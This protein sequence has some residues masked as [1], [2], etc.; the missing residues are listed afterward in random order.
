MEDIIIRGTAANGQIRAFAA[1]TK[2]LCEEARRRHDMSPIGAVALGRLLTGGAMMGTMMKNDADIVTIQIKG[3]GPIGSMTV[4]ADPRGRVKGYVANPQVMLPLKDGKL[5]IAGALGIG[6][7]S[8]IKDIGL[9]EPYV[10]DTILITSEIGDDL[11]YYFAT[12]EQVPSSVALGVLMNKDNTVEQA[13]GFI[14]QLM[15][16]AD[17]E[18]VDRLEKSVREVKSVTELLEAGM[19]PEDILRQV[20]GDM[21]FQVLD[22]ITPQFYCNCSKDRVSKAIMSIGKK[23]IQDMI[24][25]GKPI[26]VN[27]H[28]C[29]TN[30]TFSVDEL[31]EMLGVLES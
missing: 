21:D 31:K 13:G 4:T 30:Y 1:S 19:T 16:G 20:L 17:E 18:I 3:D 9:K 12:S 8:V 14:I 23:D 27:C 22:T 24:N 25:D 29:N 7:L 2:N 26:E 6:V 5:D 28:F 10:G 15:P 11:T